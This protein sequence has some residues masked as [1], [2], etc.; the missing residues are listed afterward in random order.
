M[1]KEFSYEDGYPGVDESLWPELNERIKAVLND[2]SEKMK[3]LMGEKV[4]KTRK[5]MKFLR[6]ELALR[7][8]AIVQEAKARSKQQ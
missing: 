1:P 7:I 2:H 5:E 8:K 4:N 6:N 3:K